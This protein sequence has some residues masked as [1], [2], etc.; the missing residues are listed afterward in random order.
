M[1]KNIS[2]ELADHV[3]GGGFIHCRD[4]HDNSCERNAFNKFFIV[5]NISYK[6]YLPIHAI[7]VLIFKRKKL[8]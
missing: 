8:M 1:V 7:P 2:Q 4:I 6:F 3:L 5:M